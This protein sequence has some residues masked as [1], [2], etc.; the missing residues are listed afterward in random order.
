[1]TSMA[2]E[3]WENIPDYEGLYQVSNFGRVRSLKRNKVLVSSLNNKGYARVNLCRDGKYKTIGVHRLVLMSFTD[4]SE[5]N[6]EVNHIDYVR[7]NNRLDNL[8]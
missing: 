6:E 5:W 4:E 7:S 3:I 8:E 2:T 1:M